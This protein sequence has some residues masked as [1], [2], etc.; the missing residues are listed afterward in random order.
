MRRIVLASHNA[1]KLKEIKAYFAPHGF[2][3]L[4]A[5]DCG[6][7]D[8]EETG[9]TFIENA[10]LKARAVAEHVDGSVLADDSGLEVDALGGAPGVYSARYAG[11]HGNNDSNIDK[12][13]AALKGV[14]TEKRT[15]R[16]HAMMVLM[17]HAQDPAPEIFH[18][19]WEGRILEARQGTGGFGYD[20]VFFAPEKNVSAAELDL[21]EKNILSH[22]GKALQKMLTSLTRND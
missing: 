15:A 5:A 8:V 7:E 3:I 10:I 2:E 14:P 9:T 20:P 18:G 4:F 13:L 19:V 17:K 1:G 11:E 22:R 12:L 21:D 6:C 16:F